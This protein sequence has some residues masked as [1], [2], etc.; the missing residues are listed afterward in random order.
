MIAATTTTRYYRAPN[1][2]PGWEVFHLDPDCP[3]LRAADM[4]ICTEWT[5]PPAPQHRCQSCV[6]GKV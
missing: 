1:P 6:K 4:L 2:R 5:Q 3:Y